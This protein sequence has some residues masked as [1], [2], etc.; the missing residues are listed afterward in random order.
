MFKT[1]RAFFVLAIA[2][3]AVSACAGGQ[4]LEKARGLKA[5]GSEF[6]KWLYVEY[7][8]LSEDEF[9]EDDSTDADAF[10][11]RAAAAAGGKSPQ[12]EEIAARQLPARTVGELSSARQRLMAAL[13]ASATKKI[14]AEAAH[15]QAM[16]DCW[17]QEQE[18]DFQPADINRCRS[19]FQKSMARIEDALKPMAM[20]AKPAPM[21]MKKMMEAAPFTGPYV[22]LFDFDSAELTAHGK[23]TLTRAA[24]DAAKAKPSQIKLAG[25]TDRAGNAKYNLVLSKSRVDMAAQALVGLGVAPSMIGKS[26]HGEETP[27]MAT[28]DGVRQHMNRRVVITFER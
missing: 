23:A 27:A 11:M 13:G 2:A 9:A 19:D 1:V 28:A 26:I 22:V 14:P 18:E 17:M 8:Q 6:D 5:A 21:P 10:A 7:L 25:H 4:E 15:A 3:I 24:A 20:A 12:P 16:F